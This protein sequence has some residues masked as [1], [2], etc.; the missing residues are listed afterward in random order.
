MYGNCARCTREMT[1]LRNDPR[2]SNTRPALCLDCYHEVKDLDEQ[3]QT[4]PRDVADAIRARRVEQ[5]PA[6]EVN[7]HGIR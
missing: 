4:E 1:K 3:E 6:E 5:E 2:K 7:T